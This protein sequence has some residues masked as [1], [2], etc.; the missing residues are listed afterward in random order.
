[1][2]LEVMVITNLSNLSLII[3]TML[4]AYVMLIMACYPFMAYLA[5]ESTV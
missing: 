1:M 4:I 2:D 3:V 5:I